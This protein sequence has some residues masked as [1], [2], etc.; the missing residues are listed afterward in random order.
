L[1]LGD[2]ADQARARQQA[3]D[4]ADVEQRRQN[5]A[6]IEGLVREFIPEALRRKTPKARGLVFSRKY[7]LVQSSESDGDNLAIWKNGKWELRR[8]VSGD[9]FRILGWSG[10]PDNGPRGPN[11]VDGLREGALRLLNIN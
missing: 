5:W 1:G 4:A 9:T 10:Q 7:W 8:D 3:E 6:A 2:D 11:P